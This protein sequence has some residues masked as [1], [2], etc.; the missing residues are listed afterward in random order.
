MP[1]HNCESCNYKTNYGWVYERHLKSNKH[2]KNQTLEI[3]PVIVMRYSCKLCS[4][5][6]QTSSGLWKHSQ[7]CVKE[8]TPLPQQPLDNTVLMTTLLEM[9]NKLNTRLDMLE[10]LVTVNTVNNNNNNNLNIYLNYQ[11]TH[12]NNAINMLSEFP[13]YGNINI[14]KPVKINQYKNTAL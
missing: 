14:H 8:E 12:C 5:K 6:Y 1:E 11:D 13:D 9:I 3:K 10:S 7:T 2:K 4:K